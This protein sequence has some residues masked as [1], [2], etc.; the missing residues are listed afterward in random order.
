MVYTNSSLVDCKRLSP[1]HSGQ[2]THKIDRITPHCVVGQLT[3][4]AIGDCFPKGRVASVNYGVGYDGKQC[5]IVEEKNRSWCT[6]SEAND[7]RAITIEVASDKKEPYVFTAEAY[8]GLLELCIDIC[9][10]NGFKKVLWFDDKKK[11]L[12]Y[13]PKTGECV[14]T[15]HRWFANKSC[16]GDWMYSRMGKLADEINKALNVVSNAVD[17]AGNSVI[18]KKASG[19]YIYRVQCG[20]FKT[21]ANADKLLKQIKAKKFDG[22]VVKAGSLYKVQVGAYSLKQNALNQKKAMDAL[23][24]N[25]MVVTVSRG[26][27]SFTPTVHYNGVKTPN[28]LAKEIWEGRCSD[29]RWKTWGTGETRRE[30]LKKA[31]YSYGDVQVALKKLYG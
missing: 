8:K 14:L 24:F 11:A 27:E 26:S 28:E 20:A 9:R 1:N 19:I 3:A 10:R 29:S 13:E 21:K 2:R 22:T 31:G 15:V 17:K 4:E 16:P 23:G 12:S 5:L 18:T 7:Q 6:S 30:R 25:T